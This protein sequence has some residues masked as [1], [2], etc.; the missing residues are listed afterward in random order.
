D[1][2]VATVFGPKE[3]AV[4]LPEEANIAPE[5]VGVPGMRIMGRYAA[6]E[7]AARVI[8]NYL[9]PGLSQFAIYRGYQALA[10]AMNQ[11]QLGFSAF[12]LGF[13]TVDAATSK[14]A[15]GIYQAAHGHPVQGLVS[16]VKTPLAPFTGLMLGDQMLKEYYQPGSQGDR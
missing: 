7:P 11:F 2:K 10:N 13:T 5:D 3:G 6:P 4:N 15:L 16:A 9:S 1:D 8:N 12:H 14:F